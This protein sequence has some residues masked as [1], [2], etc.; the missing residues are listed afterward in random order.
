MF[1]KQSIVRCILVIFYFKLPY[2]IEGVQLI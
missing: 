2:L 1:R